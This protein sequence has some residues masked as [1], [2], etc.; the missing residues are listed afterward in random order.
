MEACSLYVACVKDCQHSVACIFR[1]EKS[2]QLASL[3]SELQLLDSDIKQ[4]AGRHPALPV[5]T[6]KPLQLQ[7]P[8]RQHSTQLLDKRLQEGA[9]PST[10]NR[11][12]QPAAALTAPGSEA[13]GAAATGATAAA[14]LQP[15]QLPACVRPRSSGSL[16][17]SSLTAAMP[18]TP[19]L[20]THQYLMSQSVQSSA[21]QA[22][23]QPGIIL[24]QPGLSQQPGCSTTN[25]NADL[26]QHRGSSADANSVQSLQP[27]LARASNGYLMINHPYRSPSGASQQPGIDGSVMAAA[28]THGSTASG[29]SAT[30]AAGRTAT[31]VPMPTQMERQQSMHIHPR[32]L[33]FQHFHA[34]QQRQQIQ[35]QNSASHAAGSGA[36]AT[37]DQA[38]TQEAA[39]RYDT[40]CA[41]Q[42]MSS[43]AHALYYV[44][45]NAEPC[46]HYV[47]ACVLLLFPVVAA[48]SVTTCCVVTMYQCSACCPSCKAFQT[49]T[50][51]PLC[52]APF[53]RLSVALQQNVVFYLPF[54]MGLFTPLPCT[55]HDTAPHAT[56]CS[57]FACAGLGGNVCCLSLRTCS[58]ATCACASPARPL[59]QLLHCPCHPSSKALQSWQAMNLPAS[60]SSRSLSLRRTC[61]QVPP[62]LQTPRGMAKGLKLGSALLNPQLLLILRWGVVSMHA[63]V[64]V[65]GLSLHVCMWCGK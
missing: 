11:I 40:A 17:P 45:C 4:V 7:L 27:R 6:P 47:G 3:Q 53:V 13:T 5:T 28:S 26:R 25:P 10:S 8:A 65:C 23:S 37:E 59:L 61:L 63:S 29:A 18:P 30:P 42:N 55:L 60:A 56:Q 24:A 32:H 41:A 9:A 46:W 19:A 36:A 12:K 43:T 20:S 54:W 39:L 22:S 2:K 33:A 15:V 44:Y 58:S 14:S 50:P 64:L 57:T 31:A 52:L 16:H 1:Q 38:A 51:L 21:E 48:R 62:V 49:D 35:R 34:Q